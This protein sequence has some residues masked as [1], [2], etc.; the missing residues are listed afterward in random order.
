MIFALALLIGASSGCAAELALPADE[1]RGL[2]SR[3][4][5][6]GR[7]LE[8][9]D[10]SMV[11]RGGRRVW[12]QYWSVW[13]V[14]RHRCESYETEDG[15]RARC[16]DP[17]DGDPADDD[18]AEGDPLDTTDAAPDADPAADETMDDDESGA[19]G[20]PDDAE[21]TADDDESDGE[22]A[23]DEPEA[24]AE[25]DIWAAGGCRPDR[26]N[27]VNNVPEGA[28]TLPLPVDEPE[29]AMCGDADD[30][31]R[32]TVPGGAALK[33][34]V[35]FERTAGDIDLR[36]L[37]GD[38][39]RFRDAIAEGV[40]VARPYEVLWVPPERADR[41]VYV[42]VSNRRSDGARYRL[43][44][45][46]AQGAEPRLGDG[47]AA[48]L[49]LP[50]GSA[51]SGRLNEMTSDFALSCAPS[52]AADV[53]Y[54]FSIAA[55][56]AYRVQLQAEFD[57][58]LSVRAVCDAPSGEIACNDGSA[59]GTE[60]LELPVIDPG[61]YFLIVQAVRRSGTGGFSLRIDPVVP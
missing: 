50:I 5:A 46:A 38:S 55:R 56:G 42:V 52:A 25:P 17:A 18:A 26:Y 32:V 9:C 53:V 40:G 57:T 7:T 39:T 12:P 54:R 19:D 20:D 11:E 44:A 35:Y 15:S 3:C 45:E 2:A 43:H 58:V 51:V 21:Q 59:G 41:T 30:W 14:C 28:I 23:D 29:L 6:D 47:C 1:C 10:S 4:A 22:G 34:G 27:E 36:V 33:V 13:G 61:T 48:P 31:F 24:E 8:Q 16:V 49:P 60:E 37:P